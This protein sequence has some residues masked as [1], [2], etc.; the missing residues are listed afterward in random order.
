MRLDGTPVLERAITTYQTNAAGVADDSF[1]NV[2][3]NETLAYVCRDLQQDSA[4]TFA[5]KKIAPDTTTVVPSAGSNIVTP[6]L[7]KAHVIA[8]YRYLESLGYVVDSATFAKS[9]VVEYA[10][11]G[12]VNVFA[13]ITLM[14]QLR[15]MAFLV[16]FSTF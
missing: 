13:P 12:R 14:G 15:I 1:L 11:N 9:C 3:P 10:G 16:D 8:R 7:I 5:R 4:T 6:S 2:E